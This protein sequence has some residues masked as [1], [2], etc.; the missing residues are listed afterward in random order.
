MELRTKSDDTK[1]IIAL[2]CLFIGFLFI[3]NIS[4]HTATIYELQLDAETCKQVQTHGLETFSNC[5]IQAPYRPFVITSGGS[6]ILPDGSDIPITPVAANST[7]K[8]MAWSATMKTQLWIALL[9]WAVTLGLLA[10]LFRGSDEP[11]R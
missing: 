4:A 6:L 5:T 10:T 9:F 3:W 8:G 2:V 7:S 11:G 1:I